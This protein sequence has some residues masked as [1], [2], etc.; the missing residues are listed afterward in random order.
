MSGNHGD[1]VKGDRSDPTPGS[2]RAVRRP[3]CSGGT[4]H[5]S[6]PPSLLEKHRI[7]ESSSSSSFQ[8]NSVCS[9][10]LVLDLVLACLACTRVLV[11]SSDLPLLD[12]SIQ[13]APVRGAALYLRGV[14][15]NSAA[16]R[17]KG[18]PGQCQP[19]VPCLIDTT[20]SSAV[21]GSDCSC[22]FYFLSQ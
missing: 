5:L 2:V 20:A 15:N 17:R 13:C 4:L 10:K 9:N 7:G 1:L 22:L 18:F 6:Q 16:Q 3:L 8:F 14:T 11:L 19:D 21:D 12:S